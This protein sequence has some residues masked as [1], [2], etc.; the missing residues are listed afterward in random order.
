MAVQPTGR[1]VRDRRGLEL[2]LERR[3]PADAA[4]VR[5]WLTKPHHQRK[6]L[7]AAVPVTDGDSPM[8]IVLD[9]GAPVVISLAEVDGVT[10]LF[11]G[12]RVSD[13]RA[14][15]AAGPRWEYA[16][17]RLRAAVLGE[18]AP[19]AAGYLPSQRPYYERLALDGDPVSWPPS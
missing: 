3:I 14:A 7:G 5:N 17:D 16:L 19:D 18:K 6:W 1:V 8:R 11:V 2:L 9:D 12:E 10:M 15:G 4:T 13:W